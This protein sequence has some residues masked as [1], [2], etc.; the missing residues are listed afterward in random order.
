MNK[1]IEENRYICY[2]SYLSIFFLIPM[3]LKPKSKSCSFHAKQGKVLFFFQLICLA[4]SV[5]SNLVYSLNVS[6]YV[7]VVV[8]YLASLMWLIYL[9]LL[10]FGILNI[11]KG[12]NRKLPVLSK[13]VKD[14]GK[15]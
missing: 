8:G 2:L 9:T 4:I 7:G 15:D 14:K 11:T 10:V 12:L 6:V 13:F 1:D 3:Y 5:I